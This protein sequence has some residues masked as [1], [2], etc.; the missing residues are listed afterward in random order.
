MDHVPAD[1]F[2]NGVRRSATPAYWTV[3]G[4]DDF[5]SFIPVKSWP[6][7]GA[8]RGAFARTDDKVTSHIE[9]WVAGGKYPETEAETVRKRWPQLGPDE[10]VL[11][12]RY[13]IGRGHLQGAVR[14]KMRAAD[15]AVYRHVTFDPS[16]GD[17]DPQAR[18]LQSTL[19]FERVAG[20]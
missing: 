7:E 3:T 5:D 6:P 17:E 9:V 4:R 15:G 14:V 20:N 2:I 10:Q 19:W 16:G 12:V 18:R 13:Q 8:V 11:F 1:L